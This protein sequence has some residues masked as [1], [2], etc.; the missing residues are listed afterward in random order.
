MSKYLQPSQLVSPPKNSLFNIHDIMGTKLLTRLRVKFSDLRYHKFR[1]NFNCSN[2]SCLCLTGI[3]D[4]EHCVLH[5]PRFAT[6][7]RDLLDL[8][9]SLCNVE[10]M[11]LSSKQLSNL[12]LYGHPNF[13]AYGLHLV[14]KHNELFCRSLK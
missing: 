12:L 11:C 5:C 1:N 7:C 3:E 6:Q 14:E 4:N 13:T 10:I 9:S 2:L 8:V